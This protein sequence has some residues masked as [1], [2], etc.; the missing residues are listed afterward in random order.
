MAT[1][2]S[3]D[4][5]KKKTAETGKTDPADQHIE[6]QRRQK[7]MEDLVQYVWHNRP[8]YFPVYGQTNLTGHL[9]RLAEKTTEALVV[10]GALSGLV[11]GG[12]EL[13]QRIAARHAG[14]T[15][16]KMLDDVPF[17]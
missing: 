10:L 8:A 12:M 11:V 6:D 2:S 1:H 3:P 14:K 5:A 4:P 16:G 13:K 7:A 17:K 9:A 15:A